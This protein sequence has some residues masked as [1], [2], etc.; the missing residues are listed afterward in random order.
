M[1]SIFVQWIY[2]LALPTLLLL[3]SECSGFETRMSI[4][5]TTLLILW[6]LQC[7]SQPLEII[8]AIEV[9]EALVGWGHSVNIAIVNHTRNATVLWWECH[10][11]RARM[12]LNTINYI[13]K[14]FILLIF[15]HD[16]CVQFHRPALDLVG[17]YQRNGFP[18]C[19]LCTI[20]FNFGIG[21]LYTRLSLFDWK[22]N[23]L[24]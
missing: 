10:H 3:L 16:S 13:S 15:G 22:R 2:P 19:R 24:H 8:W 18:S 4:C 11:V 9:S 12:R 21:S 1:A 17:I 14:I 5:S 7:A 6:Q 23:H 20:P